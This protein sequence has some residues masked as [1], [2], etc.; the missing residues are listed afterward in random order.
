ML[1]NPF[2]FK[3]Q[4][5]ITGQVASPPVRQ[6]AALGSVNL[7][8]GD[9][10]TYTVA[11][12]AA[13]EV[14]VA[15]NGYVMPQVVYGDATMPQPLTLGVFQSFTYVDN[16]T[17][18]LVKDAKVYPKDRAV[19]NTLYASIIIDPG[20]VYSAQLDTNDTIPS[21]PLSGEFANLQTRV[22]SVGVTVPN[23]TGAGTVMYQTQAGSFTAEYPS[24]QGLTLY[25]LG[26]ANPNYMQAL[27]DIQAYILGLSEGIT[28]NS[29]T[30]ANPIVDVLLYNYAFIPLGQVDPTI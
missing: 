26:G 16:Q 1:F 8:A 28:G 23:Y 6:F 30:T 9:I 27:S 25:Q 18:Q 3:Y 12:Y 11:P 24:A 20:A 15:M 29:W 7:F 10:A 5:S 17:N 19:D 22:T 21:R 4:G 13:S 2:G 14:G